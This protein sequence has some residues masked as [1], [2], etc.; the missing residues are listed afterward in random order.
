MQFQLGFKSAR[1]P[2]EAAFAK[3]S[4]SHGQSRRGAAC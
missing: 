3:R 2:L 1:R 4:E